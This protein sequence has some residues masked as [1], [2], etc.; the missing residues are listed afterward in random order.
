MVFCS[1]CNRTGAAHRLRGTFLLSCVTPK[2]HTDM[3]RSIAWGLSA[4]ALIM[5]AQAVTG[6]AKADVPIPP[7][8]HFSADYAFYDQC[9][10]AR[11]QAAHDGGFNY[12]S[13]CRINGSG[14]VY[15]FYYGNR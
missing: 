12:V 4:A 1:G 2:G 7:G 8:A 10:A 9:N 3:K 14:P 6:T 15:A 11:S 13:P 5:G